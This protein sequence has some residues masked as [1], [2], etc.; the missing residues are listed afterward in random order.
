[1]EK[2]KSLYEITENPKTYNERKNIYEK[3]RLLDKILSTMDNDFMTIEDN[4]L[5][6]KEFNFM[7]IGFMRGKRQDLF[8]KIA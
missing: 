1:M 7:D 4:K 6:I 2:V 3:L 5:Q 8:I